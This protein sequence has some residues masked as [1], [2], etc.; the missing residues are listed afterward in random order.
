MADIWAIFEH[1]YSEMAA[2]PPYEKIPLQPLFKNHWEKPAFRKVGFSLSDTF[3]PIFKDS[4][5]VNS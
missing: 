4:A 3:S 2:E 1:F 5:S